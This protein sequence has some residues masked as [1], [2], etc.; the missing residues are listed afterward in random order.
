MKVIR[1]V[2][3]LVI[4]TASAQAEGMAGMVSQYRRAHGLS[5]VRTDAQLTAV[6]QRQA[7]AMAA[8]GVM[9][10]GAAGP[11]ATRIAGV[12][13]SA[14]GENIA[15][16][17]KTWSETLSRWKQST[18]HNANLLLPKASR[19]G[20]AVAYGGQSRKAFWALEIANIA[21]TRLLPKVRRLPAAADAAD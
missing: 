5:A 8:S 4:T 17:T 6:A 14:A 21:E 10:H 3:G 19:I 9:H 2:L 1:I 13:A 7:Q 15:A 11:F 20:V 16:G 18:A 12:H